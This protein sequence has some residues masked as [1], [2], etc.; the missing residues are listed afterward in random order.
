MD[1]RLVSLFREKKRAHANLQETDLSTDKKVTDTRQRFVKLATACKKVNDLCSRTR[2]VK[3]HPRCR[4]AQTTQPPRGVVDSCLFGPGWA[5]VQRPG[6]GQVR[7]L[8]GHRGVPGAPRGGGTFSCPESWGEPGGFSPVYLCSSWPRRGCRTTR[9]GNTPL[10][11]SSSSIIYLEYG[12]C[13]EEV[14][15]VLAYDQRASLLMPSR[16]RVPL[17]PKEATAPGS[18]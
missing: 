2:V 11:C 5:G 7:G 6:Q 14:P 4:E 3:T 1:T 8:H 13:G 10:E 12:S 16:W 17:R 9:P 15:R 18:W